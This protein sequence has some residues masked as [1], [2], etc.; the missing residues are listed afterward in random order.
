MR[1]HSVLLKAEGYTSKQVAAL[2][3][4][5]HIS[6][7]SWLAR[8]KKEGIEGLKTK[9]GRGRK[10]ILDTT[11]DKQAVLSLV[12]ENRQRLSAAKAAWEAENDKTL[13]TATFRRFL[14]SLAEGTSE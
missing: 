13:S 7:N 1:C 2:T 6:V 3:D 8:Y 10:P 9:P 12:K 5:C 14:K 11:E 4:M